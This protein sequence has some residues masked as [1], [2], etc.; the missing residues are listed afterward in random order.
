MAQELDPFGIV[1]LRP[2]TEAAIALLDIEKNKPF[3]EK[4]APPPEL[5]DARLDGIPE[6]ICTPQLSLHPD[7]RSDSNMSRTAHQDPI[8]FI[9]KY[10]DSASTQTLITLPADTTSALCLT[11]TLKCHTWIRVGARDAT[12]ASITTSTVGLY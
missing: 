9:P 7:L 3:I 8:H 1:Y 6:R 12:S 10:L 11:V 5:R 2:Q 4:V